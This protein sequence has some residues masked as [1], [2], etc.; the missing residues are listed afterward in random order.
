ME[1]VT[2]LNVSMK[3]TAVSVQRN[4]TRVW[5]G[6]CA[7]GPKVIATL[8]RKH[9]TAH[10]RDLRDGAAFGLVLSRPLRLRFAGDLHRCA[11][12]QSSARHGREQNRRER[13]RLLAHLAEVGFYREVRVKGFDSIFTCTLVAARTR[14]IRIKTELSNPIRGMMKTFGLIFPELL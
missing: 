11:P 12:C 14:L 1:D 10:K 6:K 5:R 2:G 3:E 9:A 7:S 8:L 13:C 4:G